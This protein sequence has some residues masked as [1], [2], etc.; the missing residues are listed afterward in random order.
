MAIFYFSPSAHGDGA[1]P[2]L[3][4]GCYE[5]KHT[6]PIAEV[7]ARILREYGHTVYVADANKSISA[8]IAE[9]EKA[10]A[11]YYVPY[12]TNA[13]RDPETRY[14]MIMF[15]SNAAKYKKAYDCM[16][17]ALDNVYDGDFVFKVQND[18]I[19]INTPSMMSIYF[20]LGFHTNK[21]DCDHF[22]HDAEKVGSAIADGFLKL[23]GGTKPKK[24][25]IEVDGDWGV[26]T[27][28]LA[29]KKFGTPVDG[30]ISNQLNSC[31]EYLPNAHEGSWEFEDV[32]N[33]GSALIE[34]IQEWVGAEKDGHAGGETVEKLQTKLKN[35]GLYKGKIDKFMGELT[36]KAFQTYLN[37]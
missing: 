12:H 9:A 1:N 26:D 36:V 13:F 34:A 29:Q 37:M 11:D 6:R 25:A 33:G 14:L 28:T 21:H 35:L 17:E 24:D 22:I 23:C 16:V 27:T 30:I 20:E 2:C 19:E 32:A 7:T 3:H 18:L 8:R 15:W 10:N 5:D 4:K 31:R